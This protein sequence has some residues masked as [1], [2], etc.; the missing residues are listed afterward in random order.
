MANSVNRV[1]IIGYLGKDPDIKYGPS[2]DAVCNF[3]VATSERWKGRDGEW[4]EKTEWHN[5]V[6]WKKQA[7]WAGE[8]LSKGSRVYIEGKI[9]T[10][11][12][13]DREGEKKYRTQI[14]AQTVIDLSGKEKSNE[15]DSDYSDR[16]TSRRDTRRT[17]AKARA[18][19]P[20]EITDEDIP[21]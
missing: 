5:I 1:I 14:V 13:E 7:E 15:R 3:S 4:Q 10:S 17:K 19:D 6:V 9:Q 16:D 18:S 2:G 8:N 21:F 12:W 20:G 11:S